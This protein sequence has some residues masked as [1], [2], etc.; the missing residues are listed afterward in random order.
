MSNN[1]RPGKYIIA[2]GI[3]FLLLWIYSA[4]WPTAEA[5][6]I[7]VKNISFNQAGYAEGAYTSLYKGGV[8]TFLITKYS[9]EVDGKTYIG[10]GFSKVEKL[11]GGS[12]SLIKI[13]YFDFFPAFSFSLR[14]GL[15]LLGFLFI[16]I[17]FGIMQM[18]LFVEEW[19]K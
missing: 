13:H 8:M 2:L 7:D 17:G 5:K 9:Y 3:F 14:G 4:F 12:Y 19:L 11:N 15:I 18:R 10:K 1:L 16:F 6:V